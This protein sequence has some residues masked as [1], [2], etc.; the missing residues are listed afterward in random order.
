[1][2]NLKYMLFSA[3]IVFI[4]INKEESATSIYKEQANI[5]YKY[6]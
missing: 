3:L 1:M 4:Y 2:K 6:Q 5:H